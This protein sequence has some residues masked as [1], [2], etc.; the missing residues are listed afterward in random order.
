MMNATNY[1][2]AH[3]N[4]KPSNY[5]EEL[6]REWK[7]YMHKF[8]YKSSNFLFFV[9][10]EPNDDDDDGIMGWHRNITLLA[11]IGKFFCVA[12]FAF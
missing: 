9:V 3:N 6:A 11:T 7:N 12:Q 4:S 10:G 1:L 2:N 8:M 5:S